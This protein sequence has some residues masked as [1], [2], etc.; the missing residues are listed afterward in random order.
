[1]NTHN[2]IIFHCL[3]CGRVED[4]EIEAEV[5]QCCGRTMAQAAAKTVP[6]DD[7]IAVMA[8]QPA[9]VPPVINASKKPK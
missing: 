7:T 3:S 4:A 1:M 2:D 8:G 6:D 9:R 5:P